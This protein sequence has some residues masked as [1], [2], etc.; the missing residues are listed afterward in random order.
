M[1]IRD[2][3]IL[4]VSGGDFA[5]GVIELGALELENENERRNRRP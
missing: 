3:P 5:T 4:I 2:T 1:K